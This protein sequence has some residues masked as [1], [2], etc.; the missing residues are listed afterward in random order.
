MEKEICPSGFFVLT[1]VASIHRVSFCIHPY[2]NHSQRLLVQCLALDS[3]G[4]PGMAVRLHDF[5]NAIDIFDNRLPT[6]H[7]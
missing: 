7:L 3:P 2:L 6:L 5:H 1:R 4:S